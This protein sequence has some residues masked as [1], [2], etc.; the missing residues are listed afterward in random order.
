MDCHLPQNANILSHANSFLF[1]IR[2]RTMVR[3]KDRARIYLAG[4]MGVFT[5]GAFLFT[6]LSSKKLA[7]QGNSVFEMNKHWHEQFNKTG[8][9][10]R[11][12]DLPKDYHARET[13]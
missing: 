9:M 1:S 2:F 12:E 10:A 5:A 11:V 3:A 13:K 7:N 6:A 8:Q 4:I